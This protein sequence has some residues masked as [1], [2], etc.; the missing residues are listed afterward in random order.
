MLVRCGQWE[1]STLVYGDRRIYQGTASGG[2]GVNPGGLERKQCGNT[3][4]LT[5]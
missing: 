2:R 5:P 4:Y 3:M 1:T